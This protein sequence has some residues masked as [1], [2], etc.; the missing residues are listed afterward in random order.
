MLVCCDCKIVRVKTRSHVSSLNFCLSFTYCMLQL[1]VFVLSHTL[2]PLRSLP[3]TLHPYF[4]PLVTSTHTE[5]IMSSD[6]LYKK[7]GIDVYVWWI[8]HY[9]LLCSR[10]TVL[11][12][13]IFCSSSKLTDPNTQ[14]QQLT[15]FLFSALLGWEY[16]KVLMLH[17]S[18]SLRWTPVSQHVRITV[19]PGGWESSLITSGLTWGRKEARCSYVLTQKHVSRRTYLLVYVVMRAHGCL[20]DVSSGYHAHQTVI[21]EI[22]WHRMSLFFFL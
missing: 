1:G 19:T 14:T 12:Q 8:W 16:R 18:A 17:D 10:L 4:L 11:I 22:C 9:W 6:Y 13:T 21:N 5:S 20:A 7:T 2:F 15:T 3:H